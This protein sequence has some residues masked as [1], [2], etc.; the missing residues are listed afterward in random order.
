MAYSKRD[1]LRRV[2]GLCVRC[3]FRFTGGRKHCAACARF[4]Q[5]C[6]KARRAGLPPPRAVPTLP[7]AILGEIRVLRTA[8]G[9]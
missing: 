5:A 3:G 4:A 2:L 8:S 6:A 9:E 7:R 1:L